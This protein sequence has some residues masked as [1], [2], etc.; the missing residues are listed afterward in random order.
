MSIV[1][2]KML[3]LVSL[4]VALQA[5][6][7]GVQAPSSPESRISSQRVSIEHLRISSKRS[8]AEVKAAL[9]AKLRRYDDRIA[10]LIRS[11]DVESARAELEKL[12]APTGL[13]ILQSLNPGV[14]LSLRGRPR[15]AMQY[16]IGN[17]LT[18]TEMTQHQLA[19]ALYAPIRVLLYEGPDGTAIIE[20]DRPSTLF[21]PLG[22][23]A[24]DSVARR[25]DAQLLAV[26]QEITE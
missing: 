17:V 13:T 18:A 21:A 23:Q 11:G 19:A 9:E 26:L 25:L 10:A 22:D 8:F 7:Q 4:G 12:A 20:Y 14:A 5:S 2:T 16:G 24:I 15:N 3:C 1:P 6:A